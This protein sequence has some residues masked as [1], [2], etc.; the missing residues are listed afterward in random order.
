MNASR[1]PKFR[2]GAPAGS[3]LLWSHHA[4][5]RWGTR[6]VHPRERR[7]ANLTKRPYLG[8]VGPYYGFL[9]EQLVL[10]CIRTDECWVVTSCWPRVW[11]ERKLGRNE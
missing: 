8:R 7:P 11:W 2:Q 3:K 9:A 6:Q 10:I 4:L 5:Y 1:H